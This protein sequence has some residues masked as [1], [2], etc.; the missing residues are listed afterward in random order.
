MNFMNVKSP[1]F[2]LLHGRRRVA[3]DESYQQSGRPATKAVTARLPF[4]AYL[5]LLLL[6][7]LLLRHPL[8]SACRCCCQL[9][10]HA[11][12]LNAACEGLWLPLLLQLRLRHIRHLSIIPPSKEAAVANLGWLNA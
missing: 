11:L 5:L 10:C 12:V 4:R 8:P 7:L 1:S 2:Q 3:A 6:M 9:G